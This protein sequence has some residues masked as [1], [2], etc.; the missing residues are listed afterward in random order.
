MRFHKGENSMTYASSYG[1]VHEVILV[2]WSLN[3]DI[4]RIDVA[5]KLCE[6]EQS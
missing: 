1:G 5:P 4:I 6:R 3:R 2:Y